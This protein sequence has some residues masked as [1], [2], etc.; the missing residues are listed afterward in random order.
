MKILTTAGCSVV[1]LGR[2]LGVRQVAALVVLVVGVAMVQ[3]PTLTPPTEAH[4]GDAIIGLLAVVSPNSSSPT[5]HYFS[6]VELLDVPKIFAITLPPPQVTACFSSG[7][8][9]VFYERLVKQSSQTSLVIRNLQL[10]LFSLAFSLATMLLY[11]SSDLLAL[12]MF[13]GYS[14]SVFLV[15]LLQAVGG[16]VV[17]A[18]IKYADNILKGFATSISIILSSVVSW[19]VVGDLTPGLPFLLGTCL[20]LAASLLYGLPT[21]PQPPR[22]KLPLHV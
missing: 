6:L 16:L 15:I 19:M 13:H 14:A 17:A 21:S 2:R 20:V 11:S 1:L 3:T 10:G 7:F 9:G 4:Q 12:G 22:Q 8:A 18:T 5:R